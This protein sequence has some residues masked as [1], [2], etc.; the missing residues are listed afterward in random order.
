MNHKK[1]VSPAKIILLATIYFCG[2]CA[3]LYLLMQ[4]IAGD[5]VPTLIIVGVVFA[6]A[7][8]IGWVG[9]K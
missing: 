8:L 5:N 9:G 4:S 1:S 7:A 2:A 6:F 3:C